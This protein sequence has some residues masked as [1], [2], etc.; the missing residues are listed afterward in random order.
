[1]WE[2]LLNSFANGLVAGAGMFLASA[3]FGYLLFRLTKPY[4]TKTISEI[5]AQVK[6]SGLEVEVK[7]DGKKKKK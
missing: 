5:W 3:V 6:S 2:N 4:L 7:I 1:M